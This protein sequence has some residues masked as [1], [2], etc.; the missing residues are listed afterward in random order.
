MVNSKQKFA[1]TVLL[2]KQQGIV[3]YD[4]KRSVVVFTRIWHICE[5]DF[6]PEKIHLCLLALNLKL[7]SIQ[8]KFLRHF[9][10][11]TTAL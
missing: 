10:Y 1:E 6:K 8:W 5:S 11:L 7:L 4:Y 9:Q 2:S 3:R